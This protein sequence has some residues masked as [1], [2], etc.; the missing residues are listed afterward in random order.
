[1]PNV[2]ILGLSFPIQNYQQAIDQFS[3]WIDEKES[4]QVCIANVHTVVTSTRD[5]TFHSLNAN[6]DMLTMDGQPLRWYA[7]LV[8]RAGIE[9]RVCGPELMLRCMDE[10]QQHGW[11]HYFLGGR[12]DVLQVLES[13]LKEKYPNANIVG[14]FSPPF[15]TLSES[16]D[17]DMVDQI[18][19]VQPDFLWVG[20]G[21][22]KQEIWIQEHLD[23]VKVPV[24]L[25]VGAAFDFHSGTI[26]RAPEFMQRS[27]MEWLYRLY[28]DKRL[29]KRYLTTNPIFLYYLL[30]DTFKSRLLGDKV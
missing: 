11:K 28:H 21:A 15:R 25:G 22:P 26:K 27:G 16:E 24:Q 5:R 2:N 29:W 19:S 14:A 20:L 4:R 3:R 12:E 23:R 6:A 9:E 1:M 13:K 18:N 10:G 30:K 8:H 17:Q 7:N